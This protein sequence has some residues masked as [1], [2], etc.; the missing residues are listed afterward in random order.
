GVPDEPGCTGLDDTGLDDTGTGIHVAGGL[1]SDADGH[2]D[3]VFTEAGDD[4]LLH[5]DL[6]GDCLADQAVRLRPDG[7]TSME[8][9]DDRPSPVEV[10][11]RWLGIR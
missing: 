8:R 10:L 3:S 11:L 4:L 7:G 6:D 9:C 2:A 5:T 1:D